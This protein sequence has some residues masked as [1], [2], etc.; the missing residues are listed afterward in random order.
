LHNIGLIGKAQ[1][2]KDTAADILRR[3]FL[4]TPVPFA[5]PLKEMALSIDPLIPTGWDTHVRLSRLIAAAGWD[6]AKTHYPEVRRVLQRVGQSARDSDPDY[7]LRPMR[8]TLNAAE[9]WNLPVVVTDVRYRNEADMLRAR[10]FRLVRIVRPGAGLDGEAGKHDSET[11]LDG[12][13]ADTLLT[14][15]GTLADLEEAVIRI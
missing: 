2:G 15:D 3:R 7:W 6:Y 11:E 13:A 8:T 5:A 9:A 10:G 12:F 4:Y 14:N 1:S